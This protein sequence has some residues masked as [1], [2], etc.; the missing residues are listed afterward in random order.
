MP[1]TNTP[2]RP[3]PNTYWV[4]PSRLLA[5]E[6]PGDRGVAVA[7]AK[8][9]A[10]LEGGVTHFVDL[11]SAGE[12]VAYDALLREEA[13]GLGVS[14]VYA[15]HPIADIS[16]PQTPSEMA[17]ILDA[18]DSALDV[19]GMVYVLCWGGVG[20]TG[21]VVGCWLVRHGQVRGRSPKSPSGGGAS[22]RPTANARRPKRPSSTP[23]CATGKSRSRNL[24]SKYA[25]PYCSSLQP[26]TARS[27]TAA[28]QTVNYGSERTNSGREEPL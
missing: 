1:D 6:Y 20:R 27:L 28:S 21:T 11:T 14:A 15:R 7:R 3:I 22:R 25:F 5:G 23:M 9:R 12:L 18:I 26:L 8:L 13:W 4:V 24:R 17:A 19:G 16:V 10:L 2:P